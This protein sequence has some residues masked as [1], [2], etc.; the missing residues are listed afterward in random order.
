M[1]L[2]LLSSARNYNKLVSNEFDNIQLQRKISSLT[3]LSAEEWIPP[4]M[5]FLNRINNVGDLNFDQFIEY[6]TI[7]EKVYIHGWM[8][9]QVKS[10]REMV[11]YSAFVAINNGFPFNEIIENVLSH[12]DNEGFLL[13]L[14]KDLYEPRPNQVNLIKSILLRLDFEQQDDSVI[15]TYTGRITIEHVLPQKMSNSYW[16]DRFTEKDHEEWLHKLGNLTLISG[17]KNSEAQ[18][19]D[20]DKKKS[21]YEKLNC[22]SSFDITRDLCKTEDWNL[23]AL[24]ERHEILK[25]KLIKL[26]LV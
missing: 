4:F 26:W 3:Q 25:R 14:D 10:Q 19:S 20:F 18:N 15:K 7:F 16:L 23:Q 11:C 12:A 5:A 8:R 13:S 6:V 21:I 22:K 1:S 17:S 2:L 9:K 24:I